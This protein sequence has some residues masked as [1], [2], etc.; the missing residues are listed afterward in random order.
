[1]IMALGVLLAAVY[2]IK[3]RDAVTVTIVAIQALAVGLFLINYGIEGFFVYGVSIVLALL[4]PYISKSSGQKS[5]GWMLLFLL[6][7]LINYTSQLLN[8]PKYE[9][10]YLL[11]ILPFGV[12]IYALFNL[13]KF[14]K[15]MAF[16]IVFM[17]DTVIKLIEFIELIGRL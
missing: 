8:W 11:P 15:E 6:P 3:A 5:K 14:E 1:M 13:K 4:Y 10:H 9:I 17:F 7:I 16:M 12:F 2:L